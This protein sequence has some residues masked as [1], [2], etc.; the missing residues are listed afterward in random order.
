[1]YQLEFAK[2]DVSRTVFKKKTKPILYSMSIAHFRTTI[3]VHASLTL[4]PSIL[5]Q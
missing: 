2:N 5:Q 3:E 1:M 4:H